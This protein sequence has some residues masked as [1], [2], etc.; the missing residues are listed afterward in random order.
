MYEKEFN[1]LPLWQFQNLSSFDQIA[2]YVS[3]RS[4]G[5]SKGP[6]G[7]FNLSFRV[8]DSRENVLENRRRL[9]EA[10]HIKPQKVIFPSQTHS[11]NVKVFGT[12]STEETLED[13]DAIIT[14]ER[15]VLIS[16]MSADCV[17]ILIY[18]P[19][20]HSAGA[21]HAGWRGSVGKILTKAILAMQTNFGA[22]PE[23]MIAGI[24][25][26]ICQEVYEVGAEVIAEVK[27]AFGTAQNL[28]IH[29][30]REDKAFLNLWELNKLQLLASGVPEQAIEIAEI[31]T[32]KN[33][34]MFFSARKSA[35]SA[36][37]FAAGIMV[38]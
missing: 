8:N 33:D 17:P 23:D 28:L 12:N 19:I 22:R 26:S 6:V 35:N 4:G 7:E 1:D 3:G 2:H 10:F 32:Y 25:P 14:N 37:R 16:V 34:H 9:A 27:N 11:T 5:V 13:T 20:T 36:G 30:G 15:G 21:V 29:K 38:K 24:G 18:D 31:C